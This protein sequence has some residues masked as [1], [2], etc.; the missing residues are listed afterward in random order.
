LGVKGLGEQKRLGKGDIK[1]L[2]AATTGRTL[3]DCSFMLDNFIRRGGIN[4]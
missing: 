2:E 1:R 4:L 3:T